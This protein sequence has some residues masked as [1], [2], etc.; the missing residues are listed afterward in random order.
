LQQVQ[1][2][3]G[4]GKWTSG[5]NT[6]LTREHPENETF[7]SRADFLERQGQVDGEGTS[8]HKSLG[9]DTERLIEPYFVDV[10]VDLFQRELEHHG[11]QQQDRREY[12]LDLGHGHFHGRFRSGL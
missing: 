5:T 11:V 3:T 9:G 12:V 1:L 7:G 10:E 6:N 4:P 2:E 8:E